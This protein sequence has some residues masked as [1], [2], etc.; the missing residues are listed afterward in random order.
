MKQS[1]LLL[2]ALLFMLSPLSAKVSPTTKA[3]VFGRYEGLISPVSQRFL[4][5]LISE[6]QHQQ[7]QA[8]VLLLNTPGGMLGPTKKMVQEILAAQIPV[9]I[10]VSP[11]GGKMASAGAFLV[12]A[13]DIAVMAPKTTIGAARPVDSKGNKLNG[14]M[15]EAMAEEL[16][17]MAINKGR[18]GEWAKAA[19][20]ESAGIGEKEA[21]ESGVIEGVASGESQLVL[22]LHDRQVNKNGKS[23]RLNTVKAPRVEIEMNWMEKLLSILADPNIAYLLLL[24]G[25]FGIIFEIKSPGFGMGGVLGVVS[26][27][28]ALLSF[29]SL[30]INYGGLALLI[31][32][33]VL[34]I[35]EAILVPGGIL[36]IGGAVA[37]LFGSFLLFGADSEAYRV[38]LWLIGAMVAL[39]AA[40]FLYLLKDAVKVLK[41]RALQDTASLIGQKGTCLRSA[42]PIG[43][44]HVDGEN[45]T[46]RCAEGSVKKGETVHVIGLYGLSL[47]V[48]GIVPEPPGKEE[49]TKN[50]TSPRAS[51]NKRKGKVESEREIN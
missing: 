39:S 29:G 25:F 1:T 37:M 38:S 46:A 40:V 14:E 41:R 11:Q 50:P 5:R 3:L 12:T 19:M 27:G 28:V 32:G 45:W 22:F 21:L 26:L 44:V 9:V 48:E 47:V 42:S 23:Y 49:S 7:A 17:M 36:G 43:I 18:N 34:M 20:L 16:E 31:F 51:A 6:A 8:A 10:Y 24:V 15:A 33:I 35:A 2:F 30:P 4:A 13:A